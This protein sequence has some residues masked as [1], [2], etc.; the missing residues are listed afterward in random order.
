MNQYP[1]V[2]IS[3]NDVDSTATFLTLADDTVAA[4]RAI[5]GST[6]VSTT[7]TAADVPFFFL[8]K[9][10]N[11]TIY[12]DRRTPNIFTNDILK[13]YS[14]AYTAPAAQITYAGFDAVNDS[15]T[16]TFKCDSPYGM[17][18]IAYNPYIWKFYNTRGLEYTA[19]IQ[20]ACCTDCDGD[21]GDVT[22]VL[23]EADKM[24]QS[25]NEQMNL[26]KFIG[27]EIV[28]DNSENDVVT[29]AITVTD[30]STVAVVNGSPFITFSANATIPT[31]TYLRISPANNSAPLETEPV[32]KVK[33]GVTTGKV[34]ELTTPWQGASDSGIVVDTTLTDS[35]IVAVTTTGVTKVGIKF[36]GKFYSPSSD[37]CCFP[38]FPFDWEGGKFLVVQSLSEPWPCDSLDVSTTT[39]YAP[40]HG[41]YKEVLYDEMAYLGY[42]DVREFFKD[43]ASNLVYP[44]VKE[45]DSTKTYNAWYVQFKKNLNVQ[46][47]GTVRSNS[48]YLLKVYIDSNVSV[49]AMDTLWDSIAALAGMTHE[50]NA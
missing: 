14:K 33:T 10:T 1:I 24:V 35:E 6:N 38:P 28:C 11:G 15:G 29:T 19:H 43:C 37:C 40:G 48:E 9:I 25:F 42:N 22:D 45:A 20:T 44:L 39:T 13:V 27:A 18:V 12:N 16:L 23:A 3:N 31:G 41:T 50:N 5:D 34:V 2:L 49:T 7:T 32:Y 26:T 8:E 36:T 47:F 21:C 46:G 30:S 4:I 17:K